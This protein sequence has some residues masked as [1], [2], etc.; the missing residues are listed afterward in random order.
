MVCSNFL[1]ILHLYQFYHFYLSFVKNK[2][3]LAI[4]CE[5]SY[6]RAVAVGVT[7]LSYIMVLAVCVVYS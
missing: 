7:V 2:L 6:L 1:R 3:Q 5:R 4:V